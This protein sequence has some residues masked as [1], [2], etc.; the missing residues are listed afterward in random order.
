MDELVSASL[1]NTITTVREAQ[2]TWGNQAPALR[3]PALSLQIELL[4]GCKEV[5]TTAPNGPPSLFPSLL[6]SPLSSLVFFAKVAQAGHFCSFP[7]LLHLEGI[8]A[9]K[10]S[11]IA[12]TNALILTRQQH[13][14]TLLKSFSSL[15]F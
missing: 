1:N 10:I 15:G 7:G 13:C 2:G 14:I 9:F 5:E 11:H 4:V 12:K 8:L 3:C 6:F